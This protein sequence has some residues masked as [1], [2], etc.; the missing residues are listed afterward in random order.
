MKRFVRVSVLLALGVGVMATTLA[1]ATVRG[2]D[3]DYPDIL[4]LSATHSG[5]QVELA[6]GSAVTVSLD[7]N[8]TTGFSWQLAAIGD[9]SVLQKV[10]QEFKQADGGQE[11]TLGAGGQEVWTF[12]AVGAGTSELTLEYGRPWAGGEKAV[13]TFTVSVTVR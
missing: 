1:C 9:E 13:Q 2:S 11:E 7:S 12:K 10:S 6:V 8:P 5:K 3:S 4:K